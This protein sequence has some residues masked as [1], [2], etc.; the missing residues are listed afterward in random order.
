[1]TKEEAEK[2]AD[3]MSYY[4]AVYNA[5]QGKCIPYSRA[6]KAKLYRLLKILEPYTDKEI[7]KWIDRGNGKY[8]CSI[9]HGKHVDPETGEWHE[10]FDYRYPFCPNC[11]AKLEK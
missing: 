3:N 2:Y 1:M 4:H 8:K 7:G 11:G 10:V 5:F 9:C 6:T